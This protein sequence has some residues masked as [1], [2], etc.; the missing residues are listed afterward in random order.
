MSRKANKALLPDF[1]RSEV[2]VAALLFLYNF[3]AMCAFC[4]IKPVRSALLLDRMGLIGLLIS[5]MGA[6]VLTGI[7]VLATGWVSRR[8]SSRFAVVTTTVILLINLIFFRFL[9]DWGGDWVALV[10][11]I[12]ANLFSNILFTQF[13]LLAGNQFTAREG[14]QLFGWVSAGGTVGGIA[15]SGLVFAGIEMLGTDTVNLII[16]SVVLLSACLPIIFYFEYKPR[17]IETETRETSDPVKPGIGLLREFRHLKLIALVSGTSMV[18]QTIVDYQFNAVV[19]A[20]FA[21]AEEKA[22]FFAQFFAGVNIVG[23]FLQLVLTRTILMRFGVGVALFLLPGTLLLGAIGI[24]VYPILWVALSARMGEAGMRY[25]IQ[26]ATREV[27]YLPLP[28]SVRSK[29]RPLIDIFGARFFEG[30]AGLLVLICTVVLGVS[31]SGLSVVSI[32]LISVWGIT[33]FALRH[34]YIDALRD[35]FTDMTVGVDERVSEVLDDETVDM[36][37]KGLKSPDDVQILQNLVLLDLLHDKGS[38]LP[39]LRDTLAHPSEYVR[40]QVLELLGHAGEGG[41]VHEASRLLKSRDQE[42]RIVGVRYVRQFGNHNAIAELQDLVE[43]GDLRV[44]MIALGAMV[45]TGQMTPSEILSSM[46]DL[47]DPVHPEAEA[48]RAEA[49]R[50]LGA[51]ENPACDAVMMRLL[52]DDSAV[53]VRAALESVGRVGRRIFVPIIVPLLGDDRVML[54]AQRTLQTYGNRIVGTLGDYLNDVQ[55][56]NSIRRA[57]PGCLAAVGNQHAIHVLIQALGANQTELGEHII[58]ALKELRRRDAQLVFDAEQVEKAMAD[59]VARDDVVSLRLFMGLL[60]L[61]YDSDDIL[62]AYNGL[63]SGDRSLASNAVE[64]LDNLL[65]SEHKRLVLPAVEQ[66]LVQNG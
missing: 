47:W 28:A 14:K 10:F 44:R 17:H 55:V 48:G 20:S 30:F 22:A 41:F 52:R 24:L 19:D 27:L 3:L 2:R 25:S 13:W 58:D 57:I 29:A 37:V 54:Y 49:A 53:V 59:E 60:G 56:A 64:L 34:A 39:A 21:T 18:V 23:L 6:A 11:Y 9:F 8:V 62:R 36:L 50:V 65:Q 40:A 31:I 35:L 42:N 46:D 16:F 4:V 63:V 7:V 38:I 15:G 66:W 43:E 32:V 51:L 1:S 12:W 26:E 5:Y 45:Q 33:V 61:I